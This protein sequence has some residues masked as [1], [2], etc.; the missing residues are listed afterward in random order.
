MSFQMP[1]ERD[2]SILVA[3]IKCHTPIAKIEVK[4]MYRIG[5]Y[6]CESCFR[7]I[8]KQ[9]PK[10]EEKITNELDIN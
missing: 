5:F 1:F 6:I 7:R 3:C 10:I 9:L 2:R 4:L 8:D